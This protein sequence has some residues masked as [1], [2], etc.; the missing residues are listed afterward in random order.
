MLGFKWHSDCGIGP[1]HKFQVKFRND[2]SFQSFTQL[3][4]QYCTIQLE[5]G[6]PLS[7]SNYYAQTSHSKTDVCSTPVGGSGR[8][9][10]P[11]IPDNQQ[12]VQTLPINN[13]SSTQYPRDHGFGAHHSY[14]TMQVNAAHQLLENNNAFE[15]EVE[16]EN[17]ISEEEVMRR[18][19][20]FIKDKRSLKLI[21]IVDKVWSKMQ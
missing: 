9:K 19:A 16:A 14:E 11:D 12:S 17:F 8:L 20:L 18:W 13:Q 15:T 1:L 21:E 10:G 4:E 3:L 5:D 2:L 6:S 7:R